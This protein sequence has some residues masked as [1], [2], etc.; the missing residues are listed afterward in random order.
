MPTAK[1]FRT[2]PQSG[3]RLLAVGV[4]LSPISVTPAQ[5]FESL[6]DGE[7]SG[8]TG[9]SGIT[10][11]MAASVDIGQI[12]Y[13]DE[14]ALD[15]NGFRLSGH[16]GN[17]MDNIKMTIDVAGDGEYLD[18][19]FSDLTGGSGRQFND[20]DLVIRLSA[21]DAGT[22]GDA[23]DYVHAIDMEI[24][25][26]SIVTGGRPDSTVMFQDIFLQGYLGPTD[27]TVTNVEPGLGRYLSNGNWVD[28]SELQISSHFAITDGH[29]DWEVADVIL[30]F[31]L[32]AV[33]IEG[34]RIHNERGDDTAGHF[35][36]ASV[37]AALA[38]G[39]SAATGIDG[40]SIHDVD[41]RADID[42]PVFRVGNESIGAVHFTDFAITDTSM[43]VYGH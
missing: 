39:T 29:L 4:L 34:L 32:A 36:M 37:N 15:I 28:G 30:I 23:Y 38:A 10:I 31:N 19:G 3:L 17:L 9:Q 7:L 33:G 5:A 14:G 16:G 27:I 42:M 24:S 26:D 11:E 18:Y 35:G 2:L 13:V 6:G 12:R 8:V 20:G 1:D 41:F 43:L 21:L 25:I 22:P 40:L